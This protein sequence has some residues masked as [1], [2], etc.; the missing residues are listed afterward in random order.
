MTGAEPT[1]IRYASV[2]LTAI[3]LFAL[4]PLANAENE[5]WNDPTCTEVNQAYEKTRSYPRY[6]VKMPLIKEDGSTRPYMEYT[7]SES[8]LREWRAFDKKWVTRKRELPGAWDR[9]LPKFTDCK[10][11]AEEISAS[12]PVR[13]YRM[14]WNNFPYRADTHAW[15]SV[16]DGLLRRM[17]RHFLDGR[18]R[19]PEA[20]I[21]EIFTYEGGEQGT[22]RQ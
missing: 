5:I 7:V 16:D 13:H 2:V 14:I 12:G 6:S 15:V 22:R 3:G 17:R 18:W 19:F 10:V 8:E 20:T 11:M 4:C 9:F 21:E 1:R